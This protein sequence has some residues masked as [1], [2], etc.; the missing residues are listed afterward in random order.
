MW[1][2]TCL[3]GGARPV[4]ARREAPKFGLSR[5]PIAVILDILRNYGRQRN[6]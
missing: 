1:L 4:L 5:R 6:A 2:A 3:I